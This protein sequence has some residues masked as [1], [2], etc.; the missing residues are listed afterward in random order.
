MLPHSSNS[1]RVVIVVLLTE[2]FRLK[3]HAQLAAVAACPDPSTKAA[4][5][6]KSGAWKEELQG[7]Y[8]WGIMV[9]DNF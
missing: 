8:V 1:P 2:P 7:F 6:C 3:P 5:S 9:I 4:I